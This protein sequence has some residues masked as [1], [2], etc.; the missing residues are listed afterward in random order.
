[1]S[2]SL[3]VSSG[4]PVTKAE[5]AKQAQ[6][7]RSLDGANWV[8]IIPPDGKSLMVAHVS[9]HRN[10]APRDVK[11]FFSQLVRWAKERVYSIEDPQSG[12]TIDLDNP[13][14][15]SLEF[16]PHTYRSQP[17]LMG[18]AGNWEIV[19]GD[20]GVVGRLRE[21][22]NGDIRLVFGDDEATSIPVT[23]LL[24]KIEM[25]RRS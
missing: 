5:S 16:A 13:R 18:R 23:W 25:L 2:F 7:L 8:E 11:R 22:A 3:I 1:M 19:V 9:F 21:S 17:S 14:D 15:I 20:R 4:V 12:E 6:A 10:T 24:E